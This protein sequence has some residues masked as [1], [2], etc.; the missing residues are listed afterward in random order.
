MSKFLR[1]MLQLNNLGTISIKES[2]HYN[3]FHEIEILF[4]S[5]I[6]NYSS[7]KLKHAKLSSR[8]LSYD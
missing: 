3:N 8:E 1:K 4:E 6:Q 5:Q 7:L 2:P